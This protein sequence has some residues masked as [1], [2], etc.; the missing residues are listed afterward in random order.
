LPGRTI[1]SIEFKLNFVRPAVASRGEL[2]AVARP[3]RIGRTVA[4]AEVDVL[5]SDELIAKGLFT[6]L[7][8]PLE[9]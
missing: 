9:G 5:Q 6:Y 4:V 1:T 2:M 7:V 3:V 8:S